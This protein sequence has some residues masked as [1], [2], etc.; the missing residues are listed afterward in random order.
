MKFVIGR[1]KARGRSFIGGVE[2]RTLPSQLNFAIG[3]YFILMENSC[4]CN[5]VALPVRSNVLMIDASNDDP[6]DQTAITIPNNR[7]RL[8]RGFFLASLVR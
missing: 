1:W 2:K 5:S 4:P 3:D 7:I 6:K 8:T